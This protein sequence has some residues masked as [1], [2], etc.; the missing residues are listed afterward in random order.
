MSMD[1]SGNNPRAMDETWRAEDL[2]T[3]KLAFIPSAE[4]GLDRAIALS[5]I[6]RTDTVNRAVS[7]Y[8]I[9]LERMNDGWRPAF[10]KDEDVNFVTF[11]EDPGEITWRPE[12]LTVHTLQF[13]PRAEEDLDRAMALSGHSRTDTANRAAG[14]YAFTIE[15]MNDGWQ[16]AFIRDEFMQRYVLLGS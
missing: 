15:Q 13:I 10:A 12:D 5:G 9:L 14:W 11:T 16:P 3:H 8:V 1:K 4:A 2:T 7:W 6:G